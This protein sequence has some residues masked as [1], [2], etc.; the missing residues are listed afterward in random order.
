MRC[1]NTTNT[2]VDNIVALCYNQQV[3]PTLLCVVRA[4]IGVYTDGLLGV[5]SPFQSH[6]CCPATKGPK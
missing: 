1:K 5:K 2:G 6:Q 3:R 4:P